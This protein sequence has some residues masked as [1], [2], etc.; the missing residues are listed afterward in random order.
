MRTLRRYFLWIYLASDSRMVDFICFKRKPGQAADSWCRGNLAQWSLVESTALFLW[1]LQ[2]FSPKVKLSPF[3]CYLVYLLQHPLWLFENS[4]MNLFW[5]V[6]Y[7]WFN[8]KYHCWNGVIHSTKANCFALGVSS[9][10]ALVGKDTWLSSW[11]CSDLI[12]T[13]NTQID[14]HDSLAELRTCSEVLERRWC[15]P[16]FFIAINKLT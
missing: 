13:S 9:S 1:A 7:L 10:T 16:V 15:L 6:S 14:S 8:S 12:W 11:I 4:K 5:L 2:C 3:F